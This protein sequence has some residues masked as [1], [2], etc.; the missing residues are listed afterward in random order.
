M[1]PPFK[2]ENASG[3]T[4]EGYETYYLYVLS[5]SKKLKLLLTHKASTK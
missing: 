2:L 4:A 5:E 3:V 1:I